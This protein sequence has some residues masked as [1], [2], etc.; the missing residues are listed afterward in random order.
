MRFFQG[1]L[2]F[3]QPFLFLGQAGFLS[4]DRGQRF[5]PQRLM[6]TELIG[7]LFHR[8][9]PLAGGLPIS[10]S[11]FDFLCAGEHL[12]I[13]GLFLPPFS[14]RGAG[15]VKCFLR[16]VK[17]TLQGRHHFLLFIQDSLQLL[18][19]F[20]SFG[21]FLSARGQIFQFLL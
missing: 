5:M 10:I 19:V 2:L 1:G 3:G 16:A 4:P 13:V 17:L 15:A 12:R 14:Q 6:L 8:F 21:A 9:Q 18:N 11:L 20:I 7:Q